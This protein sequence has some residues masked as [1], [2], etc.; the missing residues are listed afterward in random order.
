MIVIP[1][2]APRP[3]KTV[4]YIVIQYKEVDSVISQSHYTGTNIAVTYT[5]VASRTGRTA[6]GV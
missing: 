3:P 5:I 1:L 2:L 4:Y 6:Y